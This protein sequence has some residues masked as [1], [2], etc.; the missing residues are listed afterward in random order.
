MGCCCKKK[1][2][3]YPIEVIE[4][5][6]IDGENSITI[7]SLRSVD[8][9]ERI[10]VIGKGTFAKVFLV[11][12]KK[13]NK[14]YAMKI[15]YK[16]LIKE[17]RQQEHTITECL[18][19][20]K[21]N[22]SF[23]IKLHCS[24]QDDERLYFIMD[25]MQG[26]ELFFHLHRELR[27][28]NEK[29][30]FYTAQIII[31][32]SVL[33]EHNIIYRDLKPENI[34]IDSKGYIKLTDFGLSKIL[35]GK[36]KKATT[37][38]GT[39][40]YLAPEILVGR[41]YDYMVD[42]FSL[43][44]IMFEMLSSRPPFKI[45]TKDIMNLDVYRMP[46]SFG[47]NFTESEKDFLIGLLNILPSQRLGSGGIEEIMNH[48]YFEGVDWKGIREQSLKT[49]FK[50]DVQNEEDLRYFDKIFTEDDSMDLDD[51][52]K[53]IPE[54]TNQKD[55]YLNFSYMNQSDAGISR[56]II[57]KEEIVGKKSEKKSEKKNEKKNKKNSGFKKEKK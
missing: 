3:P 48:K 56:N 2:S 34:L 42:W 47:N 55:R 30:K 12:S 4:E 53:F 20:Q 28:E 26:G 46:I 9:Y 35:I 52:D 39:P 5:P 57:D 45:N 31:A 49:P 1:E 6:L 15:L 24:F 10:K 21:I 19:L 51:H 7:K 13:S 17:Y 29:V 18:V 40:Q 44:C 27:F 36:N 32:L 37:I 54:I 11:R 14:L 38:C 50:P 8:E 43:G 16:R 25:F 41:G 22:N 23:I 33:H